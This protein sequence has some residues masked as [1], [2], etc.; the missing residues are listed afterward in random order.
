[1][2][3]RITVGGVPWEELTEDHQQRVKDFVTGHVRRIVSEEVNS[4][5][6]KGKSMEEIKRFLKIN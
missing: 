3:T 6:E 5:I 4:M 2:K 1:M